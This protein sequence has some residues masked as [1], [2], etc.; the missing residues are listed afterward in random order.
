MP[1]TAM[2]EDVTLFLLVNGEHCFLCLDMM[3]ESINV[4]ENQCR[5]KQCDEHLIV[6]KLG[7]VELFVLIVLPES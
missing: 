6:L 5:E 7:A 2:P 3:L 4:G 1:C